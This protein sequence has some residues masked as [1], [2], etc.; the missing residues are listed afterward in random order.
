MIDQDRRNFNPEYVV[1]EL[2]KLDA[3]LNE[4]LSVYV[5]GGAVMALDGLKPGTRD[6]D[7][8]VEDEGSLGT[9]ARSLEKCEYV[10]LQPQDLSR[11]YQDLSATALENPAGFRW[12]IFL[13]YVG[14]KLVLSDTIRKRA[15]NMYSGKFLTTFRL[16]NEDLFLMKGM[17]ERD[18][19]LEDMFLI[20][21][22]GIDYDV[23]FEECR[24]Q[25]DTD[26]RGHIWESSLYLKCVELE[27]QYGIRVPFN[28]KLRQI[29]EEKMLSRPIETTLR[30]R[31]LDISEISLNLPQISPA[32]LKA[33]LRILLR[34]GRIRK[35]VN[36]KYELMD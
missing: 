22:T 4:K 14:K 3:V 30:R 17:T 33:G 27:S 20:A 24:N 31:A 8:I 32:D 34:K 9:L 26:S 28:K 35:L 25:S 1:E 7:V 19:D 5:L 23:V 21:R 11:P 18:R 13:K 12:E 6:L 16:A 15:I 36:G 10:L 29:A 2:S